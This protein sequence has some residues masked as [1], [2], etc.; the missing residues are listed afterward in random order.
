MSHDPSWS[1]MEGEEPQEESTQQ[2]QDSQASSSPYTQ[3]PPQDPATPFTMP[4]LVDVIEGRGYH[5]G[6][7]EEDNIVGGTWNDV[8]FRFILSEAEVWLR[9]SSAWNP[10]AEVLDLDSSR[11]IMVLQE[12]ANEWNRQYLQPTA[13]PSEG[14]E[15]WQIIFDQAIYVEKGMTDEQIGAALDRTLDVSLQ[16]QDTVGNLLPPVL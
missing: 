10:P 5:C 6:Y 4:R 7:D 3:A 16:A 13:Y 15:G 8:A 1:A 9:A 11:T 2:A 12:T 14:D